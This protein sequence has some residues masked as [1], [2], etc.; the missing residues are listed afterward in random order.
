L[1]IRCGLVVVLSMHLVVTSVSCAIMDVP[2]TD[3]NTIWGIWTRGAQ[4][5]RI[6][7]ENGHRVMSLSQ[8]W[9]MAMPRRLSHVSLVRQRCNKTGDRRHRLVELC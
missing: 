9:P 2:T 1:Y 8:G 3:R 4:L 5:T 7:H 6:P